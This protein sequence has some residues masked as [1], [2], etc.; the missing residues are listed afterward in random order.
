MS[1][2]KQASQ[3]IRSLSRP[4]VLPNPKPPTQTPAP[5]FVEAA[6]I[7]PDPDDP[8][9]TNEQQRM[10]MALQR[11]GHWGLAWEIYRYGNEMLMYKNSKKSSWN[12]TSEDL[13]TRRFYIYFQLLTIP[14]VV[15]ESLIKNTLTS[16]YDTSPFIRKFVDKWMEPD[17]SPGVYIN[18]VARGTLATRFAHSGGL[19][20][21][22]RWLS[23][24]EVHDMV[25]ALERYL[26]EITPDLNLAQRIDG[27]FNPPSKSVKA[28]AVSDP[29]TRSYAKTVTSKENL[30]AWAKWVDKKFYLDV[31]P[32]RR[33]IPHLRCPTE[34]GWAVDLEARLKQHVTNS[35]TTYVYGWL[36]AY[37]HLNPSSI[38]VRFP[39]PRQHCL[40]RVWEQDFLPQISEILGSVLCS[41]YIEDG[42]LN[43]AAA[44]SAPAY[45]LSKQTESLKKNATK[46]FTQHPYLQ[47]ALEVDLRRQMRRNII[48]RYLDPTRLAKLHE[49]TVQA[50]KRR[51]E[52]EA[53]NRKLDEEI[54]EAQEESRKHKAAEKKF[55]EQKH[56]T[57]LEGQVIL[58]AYQ[59]IQQNQD[60]M[61][62]DAKNAYAQFIHNMKYGKPEGLD[63]PVGTRENPKLKRLESIAAEWE[64]Q[65]ILSVSED[66]DLNTR[67]SDNEEFDAL[68]KELEESIV[69]FDKPRDENFD[70]LIS[71]ELISDELL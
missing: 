25:Q 16:D 56:Q 36:N 14:V 31:A 58:D 1:S 63:P 53:E 34:V 46:V 64:A 42:G 44:G 7:Q 10:L 26:D 20:Y 4:A 69:D 50:R 57:T 47:K 71:D 38:S 60:L 65:K 8:I 61:R 62:E 11:E 21:P 33:D 37:T 32:Q 48:A 27:V 12:L 19:P 9:Q 23:G 66:F 70:E 15:L 35:S 28:G 13:S 59:S 17:S 18:I 5:V 43:C 22:G 40:F 68:A 41:S 45:S 29:S 54:A 3:A 30:L 52:I 49:E 55:L 51:V 2:Q 24:T 39:Y 6:N 67:F